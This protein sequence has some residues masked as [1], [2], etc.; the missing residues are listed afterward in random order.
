MP[1]ASENAQ[2]RL[3]K[4]MVGERVAEWIERAVEVAEPVGDVVAEGQRLDARITEAH[5]HGQ[6]VPRREAEQERTEDNG[7]GAQRLTCTVLVPARPRH[8]RRR[9]SGRRLAAAAAPPSARLRQAT[10]RG[11]E[12]ERLAM[13]A[14]PRQPPLT[15]VRSPPRL[16]RRC[17]RR[18][19]GHRPSKVRRGAAGRC[20]RRTRRQAVDV[21]ERRRKMSTTARSSSVL[22]VNDDDVRRRC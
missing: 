17:L 21:R 20:V 19:D 16:R 13:T 22:I 10:Q 2:E 4:L 1:V 6:D 5:D 7:D 3:L 14:R 18:D 12:R 15:S 9:R 11:H 8:R